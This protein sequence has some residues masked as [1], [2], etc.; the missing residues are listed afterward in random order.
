MFFMECV[1]RIQDPVCNGL[2]ASQAALMSVSAQLGKL[3]MQDGTAI[4]E[5]HPIGK[6]ADVGS[7]KCKD[8]LVLLD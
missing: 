5:W 1:S 7:M 4:G 6:Y 2:L 3:F 8:G